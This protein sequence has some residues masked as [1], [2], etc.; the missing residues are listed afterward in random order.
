MGIKWGPDVWKCLIST[1]INGVYMPYN[2]CNHLKKASCTFLTVPMFECCHSFCALIGYD[3]TSMCQSMTPITSPEQI[4][5]RMLPTHSNTHK[6]WSIHCWYWCLLTAINLWPFISP[7][8]HS[9]LPRLRCYLRA[10]DAGTDCAWLISH[11]P[12]TA[13]NTDTLDL[14]HN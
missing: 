2:H 1:H 8:L 10:T 11:S 14:T 7:A 4:E 5:C 6:C 3:S 12:L 9:P 13:G